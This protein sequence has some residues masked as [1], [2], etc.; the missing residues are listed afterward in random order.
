MYTDFDV[1]HL[2][3]NG[4]VVL[5]GF[6]YR[7]VGSLIFTLSEVQR[8]EGDRLSVDSL[9]CPSMFVPFVISMSSSDMQFDGEASNT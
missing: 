9:L 1:S 2:V 6:Q 4:V 5:P 7:L 3:L 8:F